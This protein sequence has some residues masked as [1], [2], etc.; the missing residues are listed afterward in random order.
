MDLT[1]KSQNDR[2]GPLVKAFREELVKKNYFNERADYVS[3]EYRDVDLPFSHIERLSFDLPQVASMEQIFG[4]LEY[5]SSYNAYCKMFPGNRFMETLCNDHCNGMS[6]TEL[7]HCTYK[8]FIAMGTN[9][10]VN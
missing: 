2:V 10:H 7:E 8:G 3:N 1:L 4:F 9:N 5:F 6:S